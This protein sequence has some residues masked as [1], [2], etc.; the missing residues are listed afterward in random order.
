MPR[1]L[2]EHLSPDTG[3]K[4]ILALDGGGAKAMLSLGMLKVLEGELRRRAGGGLDFRLSDYYD[5]IGGGSCAA[6][7]AAGLALGLSVDELIEFYRRNGPGIFGRRPDDGL[8]LRPRLNA[9]RLRR[10]VQALL[11]ARTLGSD[12]IKTGL[13]FSLTRIDAGTTW[14]AT[15]HPL[16]RF[17]D[18]SEAHAFAE[19]RYRLSDLVAAS[20]GGG[21]LASDVAIAV[22][23]DE[24]RRA[25]G[26]G[27]FVDATGAANPS[28]DLF[29]LV[30][31]PVQR[32]SW[33]ASAA[34]L[35]LTSIGAGMR[36]PA[37]DG[38]A[39]RALPATARASYLVRALAHEAQVQSVKV[40][41]GL[42]APKKPWRLNGESDEA[43][44]A[45]Y[46]AQPLFD[47]QRIDVM[48]DTKP[49]PRRAGDPQPPIT[50]LERVL[51]RELD[52]D[53]LYGLDLANNGASVNLELLLEIGEAVGRTF[54]GPTY[55]DPNFDLPEWR[56]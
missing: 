31:D 11:G 38:A 50:G 16:G 34:T 44:N 49:R 40:M 17:Y 1:T 22:D 55:P 54:V 36:K 21:D 4:R 27:H 53:T 33:S 46:V 51:G 10:S 8:I 20:A 42:S 29:S 47:Y 37:I 52:A 48:L 18:Q 25:A 13:A 30:L 35:M 56:R 24:K 7:L 2:F 43:I 3:A 14:I 26:K 12:E 23:L 15:N 32:F 9:N 6:I 45:A 19:K 28:L 5:L 39:F 41:Q